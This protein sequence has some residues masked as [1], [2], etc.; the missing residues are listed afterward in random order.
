MKQNKL[1][2]LVLFFMLGMTGINC[3]QTF[4]NPLLDSGADPFS[5]YVDGHY[6]YTHTMQSKIVIWKTKNLGNL[7]D[8]ESKTIWTPPENTAY[9]KELWAPEIHYINN[10]WYV[11][12][13]ADDGNNNNHRMYVLENKS[14]DPLS[15]DWQFKGQLKVPS[16]KWAIDGNVFE[17]KDQHYMIWSGWEGD[18]NGQQDIFIA[19]MKNPTT[20]SGKRI[21]ISS[22]TYNWE[23]HGDLYG[24]GNPAQ[25][26]VNEGPQ[27]LQNGKH[28]FIVFSASGCWTVIM[29]WDYCLL[30]APMT[31][32][33]LPL[34]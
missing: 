14:K 34:G 23:T 12:F 32:S 16:D 31:C 21:K 25:V 30:K 8:A 3:A 26:N 9:S 2:W 11:Y 19:K 15:G 18:G 17:Y 33:T 27:F 5:I 24:P 7:R 6:Y 10:R 4:E 28:L 29:H 1:T 13:A 22:P 20:L